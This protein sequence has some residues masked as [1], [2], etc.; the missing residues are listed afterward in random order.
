MTEEERAAEDAY[1]KEKK[2]LKF[3]Q[4][5]YHKGA[6]YVDDDSVRSKD[7]VRKRDADGATLEDKF[8][9][10]MLPAV[11]Q[12]KNFGRAGRYGFF[13]IEPRDVESVVLMP[14]C[15]RYVFPFIIHS[16]KYTHLADQ[17]TSS[18]DS[19]WARNDGI[20][21]KYKSHLGGMKEIDGSTKR[22]RKE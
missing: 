18:R 17:D 21:E 3:M 7:D 5:Y 15:S 16:T 22:R 6:F 13:A 12:V 19:L 1:P 11:M 2:K 8:N 9:K 14:V 4:K 20:R 10:E